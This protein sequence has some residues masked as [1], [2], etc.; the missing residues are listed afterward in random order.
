MN[1]GELLIV[2]GLGLTEASCCLFERISVS[3]AI[4]KACPKMLASLMESQIWH[5]LAGSVG[6]GFRKQTLAF[7]D[8]DARHL[9][10]SLYTTGAFQA[11]TPVLRGSESM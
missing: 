11:A 10:F 4:S 9:S 7:A 8:L 2:L 5:Q 6:A 3:L 1:L